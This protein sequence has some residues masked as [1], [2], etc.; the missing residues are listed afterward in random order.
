MVK[1]YLQSLQLK[2]ENQTEENKYDNCVRIHFNNDNVCFSTENVCDF[3]FKTKEDT[4]ISIKDLQNRIVELENCI[5]ELLYIKNCNNIK[6]LCNTNYY[7]V[8]NN[9]KITI[10]NSNDGGFVVQ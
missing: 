10:K 6:N 3:V 9:G 4:E 1:K 7:E 2:K 8:S 5:G